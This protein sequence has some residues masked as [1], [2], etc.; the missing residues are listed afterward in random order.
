MVGIQ[1]AL[2]EHVYQVGMA[3]LSEAA[4]CDSVTMPAFQTLVFVTS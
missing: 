1:Q 3:L 2:S 4:L